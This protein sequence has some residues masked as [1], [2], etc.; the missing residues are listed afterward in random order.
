[1]RARLLKVWAWLLQVLIALD[2]LANALI[3][4]G[5]ADETL[6]S[7]AHRMRVKGQRYWGWTARAI[8][9]LF[10]WQRAHCAQAHA[11]ELDRLQLPPELRGTPSAPAAPQ[12]YYPPGTDP[13]QF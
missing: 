13:D 8:D 7:R 2:Q 9:A 12:P 3:P 6:S 10:F 4:G 5:W 1:M 11:D